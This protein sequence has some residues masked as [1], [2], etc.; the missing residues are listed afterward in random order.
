V[1]G[2][3]IAY[4]GGRPLRNPEGTVLLLTGAG[5]QASKAGVHQMAGNWGQR[6]RT[7]AIDHRECRG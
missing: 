5:R 2:R 3:K 6:Y 4:N 1:D 7:I